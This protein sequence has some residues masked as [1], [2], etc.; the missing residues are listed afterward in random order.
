[1]IIAVV[2]FCVKLSGTTENCKFYFGGKMSMLLPNAITQEFIP[3]TPPPQQPTLFRI[4]ET[5]T[6]EATVYRE[7]R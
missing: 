3:E 5:V 4:C 6:L 1:M 2:I 7:I